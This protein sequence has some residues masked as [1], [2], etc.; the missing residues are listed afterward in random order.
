M[1]KCAAIL[2][3]VLM[4]VSACA[5]GKDKAPTTKKTTYTTKTTDTTTAPSIDY[6]EEPGKTPLNLTY[7]TSFSDGVALVRYRDGDGAEHG[8]AINTAGDVLF[9][10]PEDMPFEGEGYKNGVRVVG[11][12]MYDKTGA[13][14]ASPELSGY[15]SLMT[16]N[17]GGYVLAK[18]AVSTVLPT[19][20]MPTVS[21]STTSTTATAAASESADSTASTTAPTEEQ[22]VAP[23]PVTVSIGVLNNKGEWVHPLST[24][25]P[26]AQALAAAAQSAATFT[27]VTED[28]LRVSVEG[29]GAPRYYHFST[30]TLT[31][32]YVHYVSFEQQGEEHAGIYRM[33]E[34]G[35]KELVL[36]NIIGDYFFEDAFIGRSVIPTYTATMG[37]IVG[38]TTLYDYEGN[39]LMDLSAY[40]LSGPLAFYYNGYLT[41]PTT[42]ELGSRLLVVLDAQGQ[43]VSDPLVLGMRDVYY[44]PD[45]SGFVVESYTADGAVTY[46]HYDYT[47]AVTEYADVTFFLGFHEGLAVATLRGDEERYYYINHRAEIVLR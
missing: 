20:E 36:K 15:E 2:C 44:A 47:G 8:A 16:G 13:V 28:V 23:A 24:D 37:T 42:D 35:S 45:V 25:H 10:M 26:I 29:V 39:E 11:D 18:M 27:Y 7:A 21:E 22:P 31:A 9:E 41:L 40:P 6:T 46:R 43:P 3:A 5:C 14:I 1:R 12:V 32:D 4:T 38:P 34:D 33:A 30:N 17:C 19:P